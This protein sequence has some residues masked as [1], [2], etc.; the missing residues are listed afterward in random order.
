[1]MLTIAGISL[2]AGQG[3]GGGAF[4]GANSTGGATSMAKSSGS[5]SSQPTPGP[6]NPKPGR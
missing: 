1:M 3:T 2:L 5:T 6:S 4:V